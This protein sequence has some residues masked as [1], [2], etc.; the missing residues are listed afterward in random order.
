MSSFSWSPLSS[1]S[2]SSGVSSVNSLTG[3]LTLAAG[4][5]ITITHS[6]NTLTIAAS[7]GGGLPS[8]LSASASY[9]P[10]GLG[11]GT[12]LGN[13]TD[14]DQTNFQIVL[15]ST[16]TSVA[17]NS[18]SNVILASGSYLDSGV[19]GVGNLTLMTGN[20]PSGTTSGGTITVTT[21]TVDGG[22]AGGINIQG[23]ASNTGAAGDISIAAGTNNVG[24]RGG[25]I[26]LVAGDNG[27]ASVVGG[28][29]S[30][31]AG[32]GSAKG[33][34]LFKDD[35]TFDTGTIARVITKNND[36]TATKN[37]YVASGDASSGVSGNVTVA[38]GQ[39][40][41]TAT[42]NLTLITGDTISADVN[43]GSITIGTGVVSGIGVR[44]T[45][46]LVNGSE[47]ISGQVWTSI[48]A[49]GNGAW[50]FPTVATLTGDATISA[51]KNVLSLPN[52][53]TTLTFPVGVDGMTFNFGI[54]AANDPAYAIVFAGSGGNTID[55]NLTTAANSLIT[56][57]PSLTATFFSGVWYAV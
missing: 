18:T 37:L 50:A 56:T 14:S 27:D 21:G 40:D 22:P 52:A 11:P 3:A 4:S 10:N 6:G 25:N 12:F 39:T 33:M 28:N 13:D 42:G 55:A 29:I 16:D 9:T 24:H 35:L 36:S 8:P 2:G 54:S 49:S 47:G 30:L 48:D 15:G 41:T 19:G 57:A 17:N 51:K 44:G 53:T 20:V 34:I 43:S 31:A 46:A 32:N 5:N 26:S 1:G 38:S 45:I 7:G 23:G